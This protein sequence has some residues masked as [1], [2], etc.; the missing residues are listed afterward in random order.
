LSNGTS[1][2][3]A[4]RFGPA[5]LARKTQLVYADLWERHVLPRLRGHRSGRIT[6]KIIERFQ[7]DLRDAGLG[8]PTII[9][10]L[11]LLQGVL[12]RA[13]MSG[14]IPSNPVAVISKPPS[15]LSLGETK[16]TKTRRSRSVRILAPLERDLEE[17]KSASAA[18]ARITS[19]SLVETGCRGATTTTGTGGS[20]SSD[21]LRA[22]LAFVCR[23]P[24]TFVT[25]SSRSCSR[26]DANVLDI[27]GQAGRAPSP[28][29]DLHGPLVAGLDASEKRRAE[30]IIFLPFKSATRKR[31]APMTPQV[32]RNQTIRPHER[33]DRGRAARA[34]R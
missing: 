7:A 30:D 9:M 21:H 3:V 27:A 33:P 10:V 14:R 22:P 17:W 32:P 16:E 19:S 34:R 24:T 18:N 23:G 2:G 5:R 25:R 29:Y 28:T 13:V 11:A 31:R 15:G 1:D 6:P 20:A 26:R 8:D 4:R 12:T